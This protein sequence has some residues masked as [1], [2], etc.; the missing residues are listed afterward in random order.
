MVFEGDQNSK[1]ITK[2]LNP[3]AQRPSCDVS[4]LWKNDV[5]YPANF[6]DLEHVVGRITLNQTH[7]A[8]VVGTSF[9]SDKIIDCFFEIVMVWCYQ[10]E[11][12][13]VFCF[14]SQILSKLITSSK[15]NKQ[16]LHFLKRNSLFN[17]K[18]WLMPT[19]AQDVW[20]LSVIFF[21]KKIIC[22]L[23]YPKNFNFQKLN[24]QL[25][26]ILNHVNS[27][28]TGINWSDWSFFVPDDVLQIVDDSSI[29][30]CG[31]AFLIVEKKIEINFKEMN[32]L[33]K[34]VINVIL[35][36][37]IEKNM[38][39]LKYKKKVILENKKKLE[40]IEQLMSRKYLP[41][42]FKSTFEFLKYL[43]MC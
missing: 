2:N 10:R 43:S 17:Y 14:Q 23:N 42:V 38:M 3:K 34:A 26:A 37:S 24:K 30:V 4:F 8:T 6:P 25:Q 15:V 16:D 35:S 13:S 18:V 41:A 11:K 27:S 40:P 36:S 39:K 7:F 22:H 12:N 1:T 21:Q 5:D 28:P 20:Y 31:L 33:K 32:N 9:I 19:F 29:Y